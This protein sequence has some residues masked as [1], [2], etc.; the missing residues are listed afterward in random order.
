MADTHSTSKGRSGRNF[1]PE[2]GKPKFATRTRVSAELRRI[3]TEPNVRGRV[4]GPT[5]K[6]GREAAEFGPRIRVRGRLREMIR[7]EMFNLEKAESILRC[8]AMS[9]ETGGVDAESPYYPDIVE[10]ASD[11][12]KRSLVD[13]DV[14][15]DGYIRDPLMAARYIER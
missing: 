12:I 13:L 3:P 5:R 6:G 15:Y 2:A 1:P 7:A 14:L 10:V 9:M 11:L 8:L 4:P